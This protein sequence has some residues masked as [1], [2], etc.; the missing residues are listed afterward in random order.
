MLV[1]D[2]MHNATKISSDTTVSEAAAMMD[3][4][5]IGSVLVEKNNK[6]MGIMTGGDI[7]R[8]IVA[9]GENSDVLRVKDIM[10][11]P[12]ITIE[13]NEDIEA[14]SRKMCH[15]KIRRLVVTENNEII[16]KIT[17]NSISRSIKYLSVRESPVYTR[18]EY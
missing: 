1:N 13:A 3:Q 9:K 11:Y 7:L 15:N 5:S 12:I 2:I 10:S 14:A 18:P 4:K 16:G 6:I 8:K 17:A